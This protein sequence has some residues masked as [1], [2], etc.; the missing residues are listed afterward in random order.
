M[1]LSTPEIVKLREEVVSAAAESRFKDVGA[2]LSKLKAGVAASEDVIRQTKIGQAVGKLRNSTD[3]ATSQAAK[4]LVTGWKAQVEKQRGGAN[5]SVKKKA[6]SPQTPS[7]PKTPA[8]SDRAASAPKT[9]ASPAT[10]VVKDA[11]S[12]GKTSK[13]SLDFQKLGDKTRNACLKLLYDALEIGSDA[14][15]AIIFQRAL[16]IERATF[17]IVGKEEVSGDYRSKIRS[18]SLN[19]KDAKNPSLRQRVVEGILPAD[20]LIQMKPEEMASDEVKAEREKLQVQNLFG[21]KAAEDQA[22]ETDAFECGRCKQRKTRYY[23][24]QTRSADEPMTTFVT[25]VVC[26]NKWKF[27]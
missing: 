8:A 11:S 23:Q 18:L 26:N 9:P 12:A 25:C 14:D 6:S 27:C 10:P 15:P 5:G 20:V 19:L 16:A 22:A 7:T 3:K 2:I 13:A 21:S 1:P 4:E 17:T 24:K